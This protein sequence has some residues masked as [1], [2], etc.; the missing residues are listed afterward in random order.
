MKDAS[1]SIADLRSGVDQAPGHLVITDKSGVVVYANQAVSDH[2]GFSL[3]EIIGRRPGNLWGGHMASSFYETLWRTIENKK[4]F[5]SMVKNISKQGRAYREPFHV[6]PLLDTAEKPRYFLQMMGAIT[7]HRTQ[8][9]FSGEFYRTFQQGRRDAAV[10]RWIVSWLS[11]D[12]DLGD[13]IPPHSALTDLLTDLLVAPVAEKFAY[14]NG[15]A[16]LVAGAKEKSAA[17]AALY[18]KYAPSIQHYFV[19]RTHD[20]PSAEELTQDTFLLAFKHLTDFQITNAS[21][22]TYLFHIA[23]NLL[24]SFY[25]RTHATVSFDELPEMGVQ[26]QKRPEAVIFDVDTWRVV[27][28]LLSPIEQ[29]VIRMKYWEEASIEQIAQACSKS[30][31]AVKL[32]LSRARKKLSQYPERLL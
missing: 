10:F 17:F 32:H 4:P 9:I 8:E 19:E 25:R 14:R 1:S 27:A 7:S 20:W 28:S 13:I 26:K 3:A 31:N 16:M 12:K 24:V 30:H 29:R 23:H 18:T 22:R 5:V 11:L 2:T 15:D 6:A 21:Y